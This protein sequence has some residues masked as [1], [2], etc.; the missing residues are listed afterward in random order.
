[1]AF[2]IVGKLV[3]PLRTSYQTKGVLWRLNFLSHDFGKVELYFGQI[4]TFK[5]FTNYMY[6]ST[7]LREVLK[8]SFKSA[9]FWFHKMEFEKSGFKPLWFSP[10]QLLSS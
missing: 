8:A 10:L 2:A 5:S 3:H 7:R 1:M 9:K 6:H 4:L